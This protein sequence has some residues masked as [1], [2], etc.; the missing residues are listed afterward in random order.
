MVR[1][2]TK[3]GKGKGVGALLAGGL[4]LF[5][6]TAVPEASAQPALPTFQ[7]PREL[8]VTSMVKDSSVTKQPNQNNPKN[9]VSFGDSMAANPTELD[10]IMDGAINKG[11]PIKW[12]TI[13]GDRCAQDPNNFARQ[14]ARQTGLRLS[15][16]SCAG[17]TAYTKSSPIVPNKRTDIGYY[18]DKAIRAGDLNGDTQLVTMLIGFNE[19]YQKGHWNMTPKQRAAAYRNAMVPNLQKIKAAAPNAQIQLLGYPDETDGHNNTC[20]TNLMGVQTHWYF[21]FVGYFQDNLYD[22]QKSAANET[23]VTYMPFKDE[24]NVAKGNSGC[25]KHG[26]RL[27]STFVDDSSH[28]FSIHLTDNGHKYYAR[29]ILEQYNQ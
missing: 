7:P 14:V 25:L 8:D 6:L 3:F 23:G 24:I 11:A 18:V 5:S 16:Y 12:P 20:G 22:Q 15:D 28:N 10:V 27:N 21:P 29:R 2:H 1:N 26:P 9:Y 19:F 13:D 17:L 4:A